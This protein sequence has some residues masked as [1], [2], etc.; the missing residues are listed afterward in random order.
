MLN[1]PVTPIC[2]RRSNKL[3]LLVFVFCSWSYSYFVF[4]HF[5]YC[6]AE[7]L[8]FFGFTQLARKSNFTLGLLKLTELLNKTLRMKM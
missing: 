6:S 2:K 1:K 7:V 4:L 3:I 8:L 5:Y